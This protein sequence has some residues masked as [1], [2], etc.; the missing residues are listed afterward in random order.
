MHGLLIAVVSLVVE[1][2]LKGPR[3]SGV[4]VHG[5]WST[6]SVVEAHGL[7]CSEARGSFSDQG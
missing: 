3:A 6:G 7:S 1:H 4:A 2:W 5:L